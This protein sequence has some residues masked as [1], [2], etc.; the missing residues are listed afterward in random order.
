MYATNTKIKKYLIA[1]GFKNLYFFPHLRFMK[2]WIVDEV[3]FDAIGYKEGDKRLWMFQ[4]KT[5]SICPKKIKILYKK[6]E[7]KYSCV[8]CWITLFTKKKGQIEIT[9]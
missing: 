3:G 1:E 4:F 7:K 6:I 9:S 2:D 8:A 5:N